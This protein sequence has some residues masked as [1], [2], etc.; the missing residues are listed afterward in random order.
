MEPQ[1]FFNIF[2]I[3]YKLFHNFLSFVKYLV[4]IILLRVQQTSCVLDRL[5]MTEV[6]NFFLFSKPSRTWENCWERRA[7]REEITGYF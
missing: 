6:E 4:I 1:I 2:Q 7:K 5:W 3:S